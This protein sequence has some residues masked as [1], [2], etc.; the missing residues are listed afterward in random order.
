MQKSAL[1]FAIIGCGRIAQRH[2][3]HISNKAHLT[4]VCDIIPERADALAKQYHAKAYYSVTEL[5]KDCHTF[6]V[7][8]I[9]S[10]NGFQ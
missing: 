5:L 10:P 8:S 7:A 2:A 4:A 3:E 1:R 6:D 9:C